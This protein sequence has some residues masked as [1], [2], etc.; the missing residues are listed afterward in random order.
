MRRGTHTRL[1]SHGESRIL[2]GAEG[3]TGERDEFGFTF[4]PKLITLP[5]HRYFP[6]RCPP[7]STSA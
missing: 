7:F 1:Y 2:R 4:G 6:P 3:T 5:P